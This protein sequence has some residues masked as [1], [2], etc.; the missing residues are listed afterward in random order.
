[1]PTQVYELL[2]LY[3]RYIFI[4]LLGIIAL[5]SYIWLARDHHAHMK[6]MRKLPDAGLVGEL[7][8]QRSG[9]TLPLPREGTMG[10]SRNCDIY[11]KRSKAARLHA[12]IRFIEGKGVKIIPHRRYQ[13]VLDGR[14]LHNQGY[15]YHGSIIE[16]GDCVMR[17]RLFA[18]L[19][20]PYKPAYG[21]QGQAPEMEDNDNF[22]PLDAQANEDFIS[23]PTIENQADMTWTHAPYPMDMLEHM[24]NNTQN[25]DTLLDFM[26]VSNI[27]QKEN[28]Q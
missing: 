20:I 2:S 19:N 13:V 12:T 14:I 23:D 7:V 9:R 25:E 4:L 28:R 24:Q 15:A 5:R 27:E 3:M 22:M 1:M 21:A 17:V 18:G 6:E 11:L 8:I 16:I 10:A 26:P